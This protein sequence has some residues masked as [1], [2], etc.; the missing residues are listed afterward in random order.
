MSFAIIKVMRVKTRADLAGLTAHGRRMDRSPHVDRSRSHL[1][2]HWSP[3][4]L[5]LDDPSDLTEAVDAVIAKAGA[6]T[7]KGSAVAA[8]FHLGASPGFFEQEDGSWDYERIGAWYKAN[9]LAMLERFPG[10]IASV[11]LDLDESSPHIAVYLVPLVT[12]TTKHCS[13]PVV[14]FRKLLGGESKSQASSRM[15]E[16]QDWYAERMKPLG[17]RRGVPKVVTGRVGLSHQQYRRR[18]EIEDTR[19]LEAAARAE[20]AARDAELKVRELERQLAAVKWERRRLAELGE[21]MQS[22]G[23]LQ[24][25]FGGPTV[26]NEADPQNSFGRPATLCQR[27]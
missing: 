9:R 11:R 10:M 17:L 27:L 8:D 7:H 2:H 3:P 21:H 13:G 23:D 16:L 6:K 12:K 24:D 19:R 1:N 14:S 4:A 18:Q 26:E 15:I 25:K 5:E 20:A 22:I